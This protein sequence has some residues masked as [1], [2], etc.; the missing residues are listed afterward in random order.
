MSNIAL[1]GNTCKLTLP[2]KYIEEEYKVLR[3]RE[4]QQ[5]RESADPKVSGAGVAVKP[6]RKWRAEATVEQAEPWLRHRV[7]VGT[8]A[9]GRAG[10]GTIVASHFYKARGNEWR[11]LVQKEQRWRRRNPAE[12]WE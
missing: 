11:Q 8:V 12:Q 4:V 9:R 7:L 1:Y 6:G 10:R 3:A 2:L 5:F